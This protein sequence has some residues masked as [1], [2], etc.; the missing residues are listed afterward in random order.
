MTTCA[1]CSFETQEDFAFCPKCGTRQVGGESGDPMI[2]RTLAGKYRVIEEI[3]AGSM[4][5]VYRA[6]HIALRKPIA[7]KL[8]RRDLQ[9]ADEALKRFQREGIAAGQVSHP[10]VIQIF[11]FDKA[12]ESHHAFHPSGLAKSKELL[13]LSRFGTDDDFLQHAQR[14]WSSVSHHTEWRKL[15][16]DLQGAAVREAVRFVSVSQPGAGAFLNAVPK[17]GRCR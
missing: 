10:N 7:L 17:H 6:E 1:H 3:G 15:L 9:L 5:T 4:G 13:P 16:L 11:D 14:R 2:G 8:L 12:G